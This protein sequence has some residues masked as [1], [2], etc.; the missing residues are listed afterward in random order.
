MSQWFRVLTPRPQAKKCLVII[1][2]A[3]GGPAFYRDWAKQMPND[4]E[5]VA[6]QLPG[7]EARWKEKPFTR[8][9]PLI[10]SLVK[11]LRPLW[12][13]KVTLFGHSLG[14]LI[15]Y[16]LARH[17]RVDRLI[18]AGARAPQM[19]RMNA[20]LHDLNDTA[21]RLELKRLGGT[22][23]EVLDNEELFGLF[24][25]AM[26]ADLEVLETYSREQ[27][28]P[29]HVPM[30]VLGGFADERVPLRDLGRWRD[31]NGGPTQITGMA[32]GHFF[33][34]SR[35]IMSDFF[36]NDELFMVDLN[37]DAAVVDQYRKCLDQSE[38]HRA[39]RFLRPEHQKRFIVARG[40]L[41]YA[42]G[43]RIGTKP[44]EIRIVV[45]PSGKPQLHAEHG[46]DVRF[47]LSHSDDLAIILISHGQEVGVDIERIRGDVDH[48]GLA[49]R[50]FAPVERA[51]VLAKNEKD[52]PAR[53]FAYWTGKEAYSKSRGLGLNLPLD[54][55]DIHLDE[56][57]QPTSV[58]DRTLP[59]DRVAW[60]V[61]GLNVV[62][63]FAAAISSERAMSQLRLRC[64]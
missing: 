63:G 59:G 5:V 53:F 16:E 25:P 21:L 58:A 6:V 14:A 23:A 26:R 33:L 28:P 13:R 3:G 7:R 47:N 9:E 2:H 50:Y 61:S 17:M 15:A 8:M 42:L 1:P 4:V 12:D 31:V 27:E 56:H 45:S 44:D 19:P 40:V 46:S 29:L 54:E 38:Q 39:D 55:Y 24:L 22:P 35:S 10:A 32:G 36:A 52:R 18:V 62:D 60:H 48:A 64:S 34:D 51:D 30:Q 41:R 20:S 43:Q 49:E 57:G 11:E 37:R